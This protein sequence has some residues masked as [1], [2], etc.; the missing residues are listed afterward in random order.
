MYIP[1]IIIAVK[2]AMDSVDNSQQGITAASATFKLFLNA[3]EQC[4]DVRNP[5]G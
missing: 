1:L 4:V 5:D 2:S 3:P